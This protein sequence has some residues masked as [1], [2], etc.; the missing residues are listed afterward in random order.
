MHMLCKGEEAQRMHQAHLLVWHLLWSDCLMSV[1]SYI[2]IVPR[3][4]SCLLEA[5]APKADRDSHI[6]TINTATAIEAFQYP[7]QLCV[8][9]HVIQCA[10]LLGISW[11]GMAQVHL[12]S[13]FQ[14]HQA[15]G[16]WYA[17]G[18]LHQLLC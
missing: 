13:P 9:M 17:G 7:Q 18:V 4:I 14:L 6:I 11:E 8:S 3:H 2:I 12:P 15:S 10:S 16:C 1:L 5:V